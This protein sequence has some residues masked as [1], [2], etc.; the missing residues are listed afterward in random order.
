MTLITDITIYPE[1]NQKILET[2]EEASR[3]FVRQNPTMICEKELYEDIHKALNI[4]RIK[5]GTTYSE[6]DFGLIYRTYY[7]YV[8]YLE[9]VLIADKKSLKTA[10]IF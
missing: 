9:N 4:I 10:R 5:C 2:L 1:L 6:K 8:S 7:A 3:I